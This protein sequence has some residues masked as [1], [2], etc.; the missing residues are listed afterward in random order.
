MKKVL[1]NSFFYL[2]LLALTLSGIACTSTNSESKGQAAENIKVIDTLM[3]RYSYDHLSTPI[4]GSM[5]KALYLGLKL[6]PKLETRLASEKA[7]LRINIYD[8]ITLN[9]EGYPP[10]KLRK[11]ELEFKDSIGV[12]GIY[13]NHRKEKF[14]V[15]LKSYD[16]G[17]TYRMTI[18]GPNVQVIA[19]V[20]KTE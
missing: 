12:L 2:S 14:S 16:A 1:T 18:K 17:I 5:H 20:S 13:M 3:N 8:H 10:L 4:L 6:Q 9:L 11:K 15:N 19:D 7:T